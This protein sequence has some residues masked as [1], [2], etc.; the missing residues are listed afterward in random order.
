MSQAKKLSESSTTASE[1]SNDAAEITDDK[2]TFVKGSAEAK[3]KTASVLAMEKGGKRGPTFQKTTKKV[4]LYVSSS[5]SDSSSY[6]Y[7]QNCEFAGDGD[8]VCYAHFSYCPKLFRKTSNS[9][10]KTTKSSTIQVVLLP[11]KTEK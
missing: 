5:D 7:E 1:N 11:K 3:E 4:E 9:P 10:S 2:S 6:D 8:P